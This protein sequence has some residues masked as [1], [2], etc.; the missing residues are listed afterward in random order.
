MGLSEGQGR[1]ADSQGARDSRFGVFIVGLVREGSLIV[2]ELGIC[3]IFI[4]NRIGD[5]A[6]YRFLSNCNQITSSPRQESLLIWPHFFQYNRYVSCAKERV[7]HACRRTQMTVT[8]RPV[9]ENYPPSPQGWL[10]RG[11][12]KMQIP[13]GGG[14][15][16][17]CSCSRNSG[18]NC[19]GFF[20]RKLCHLTLANN[21]RSLPKYSTNATSRPRHHARSIAICGGLRA[22]PSDEDFPDF[23]LE[24]APKMARYKIYKSRTTPQ[25]YSIQIQIHKG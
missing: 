1:P 17:C 3:L 23:F 5:T 8:G 18:Q 4:R 24:K 2:F 6:T 19:D 20:R 11:G 22:R 9:F 21:E 12:Q 10:F 7:G 14:G 16:G 13:G 15:G 25:T